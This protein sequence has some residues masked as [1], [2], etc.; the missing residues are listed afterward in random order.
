[1][2]QLNLHT[3]RIVKHDVIAVCGAAGS[4]K[5]SFY[6]M[7]VSKPRFPTRNVKFA[8]PLN[9]L[10][11]K[12][13]GKEVSYN[14]RDADQRVSVAK[15][16]EVLAEVGIP[17]DRVMVVTE[18]FHL[19]WR[20]LA[21]YVGTAIIRGQDP[22]F[23]VRQVE[24]ET[25]VNSNKGDI[26]MLTDARFI[27]EIDIA[28]MAILLK[29]DTDVRLEFDSFTHESE[30]V[31]EHI[32][33]WSNRYLACRDQSQAELA[34][35]CLGKVKELFEELG[36]VVH[37]VYQTMLDAEGVLVFKPLEE[38]YRCFEFDK[39]VRDMDWFE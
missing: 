26:S 3:H 10:L 12:L 15:L 2:T 4:G 8:T 9:E 6:N 16:K 21:Q 14:E 28:T 35:Y 5:D 25:D 24:A 29:R 19:S 30:V 39:D 31:G 27:N 32:S 18:Y 20:Q 1:M 11:T 22:E 37:A 36:L 38:A 23:F 34:D 13:L 7:W 33:V 17:A